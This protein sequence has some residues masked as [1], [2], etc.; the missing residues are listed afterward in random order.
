M[1]NKKQPEIIEAF[2]FVIGRN[3]NSGF[4]KTKPWIFLFVL[5]P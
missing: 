4:G 2:V 1:G 5:R 3:T